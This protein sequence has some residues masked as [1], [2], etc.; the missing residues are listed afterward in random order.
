VYLI[1]RDRVISARERK[2]SDTEISVG[3]TRAQVIALLGTPNQELHKPELARVSGKDSCEAKAELQF[4]YVVWRGQSGR[5]RDVYF[6]AQGRV[7]CQSFGFI[8]T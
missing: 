7:I 8:A 3:M 5:F 1:A 2:L 4:G 6:D